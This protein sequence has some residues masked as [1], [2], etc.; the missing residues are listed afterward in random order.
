MQGRTWPAAPNVS[1]DLLHV[2]HRRV[3][4]SSRRIVRLGQVTRS[5]SSWPTFVAQNPTDPI[6]QRGGMARQF[7]TAKSRWQAEGVG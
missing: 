2:I 4:I 6:P 5:D 1:K 3:D 7:N